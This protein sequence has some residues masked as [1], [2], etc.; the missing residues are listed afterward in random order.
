VIRNPYPGPDH[1]QTLIIS[2]GS[3]LAHACRVWST[4]VIAIVSYAARMERPITL[5]ASHGKVIVIIIVRQGVWPPGSADTACPR[6]PLITQVQHFISRIKK[7]Q[8]WDVQTMWAYDLDLWPWRSW[9]PWLMRVDVLHPLAKFEVRR[10]CHWE[11]M[12][13][14]VCQY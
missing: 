5:S 13:H 3:S 10:P 9:R 14:D 12:A 1:H 2:R 4:S 6:P 7:R 8:R 11:D